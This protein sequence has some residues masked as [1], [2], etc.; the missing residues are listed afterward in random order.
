MNNLRQLVQRTGFIT[1]IICVMIGSVGLSDDKQPPPIAKPAAPVPDAERFIYKTVGDV[2][3]PLYVVKPDDWQAGESRPAVVF[4]F[5][6][7]WR[8]ESFAV[9]SSGQILCLTRHGRGVCRVP[10]GVASSGQG[11]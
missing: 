4:Y 9:R 11:G 3:L 7:G 6:G 2:E 1:G 8:G 5:G 10:R